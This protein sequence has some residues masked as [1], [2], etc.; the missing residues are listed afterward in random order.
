MRVCCCILLYM[1]SKRIAPHHTC[2][3]RTI[4]H[5]IG[6][7]L[8]LPSFSSKV[9]ILSLYHVHHIMSSFA[10]GSK[11]ILQ[12]LS[13][14]SHYNGTCGVVKSSYSANGWTERVHQRLKIVVLVMLLPLM[15]LAVLMW[16]DGWGIY[17]SVHVR[18]AKAWRVIPYCI[19]TTMVCQESNE[20][21]H[22][23]SFEFIHQYGAWCKEGR[24]GGEG[25]VLNIVRCW[26]VVYVS[27]S[28]N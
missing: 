19:A 28:R 9:Y 5:D 23:E 21:E 17:C 10:I 27:K 13:N 16:K 15:V 18:L 1:F 25:S 4:S 22:T 7:I 3:L 12:N 11:V 8:Y 24:V 14:G 20:Q 2:S 6:N 26:V